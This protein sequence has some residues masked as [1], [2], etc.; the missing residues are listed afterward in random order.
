MFGL[1][2]EIPDRVVAS[3]GAILR[4]DCVE[5]AYGGADDNCFVFVPG[6]VARDALSLG[7]PRF[8]VFVERPCNAR[9]RVRLLAHYEGRHHFRFSGCRLRKSA[10]SLAFLPVP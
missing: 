5:V 10:I 8:A 4:V 2:F 6:L 9:G 3:T 1:P 7:S